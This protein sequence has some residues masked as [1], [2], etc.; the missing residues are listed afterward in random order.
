MKEARDEKEGRK[1]GRKEGSIPFSFSLC[2]Y[3][4]LPPFPSSFMIV[5]WVVCLYRTL[6]P[7]P[8]PPSL[9]MQVFPLAMP[10]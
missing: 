4:Q 7:S 10:A 8:L 9:P 5:L 6:C 3:L 2:G 1:E